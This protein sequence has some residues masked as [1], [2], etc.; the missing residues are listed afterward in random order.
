MQEDKLNVKIEG[1]D[2]P[3][4]DDLIIPIDKIRIKFKDRSSPSVCL[5]KWNLQR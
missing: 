3:M 2:K 4:G 1:K 5:R